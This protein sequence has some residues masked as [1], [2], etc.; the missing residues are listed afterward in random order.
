MEVKYPMNTY[1]PVRIATEWLVRR[2]AHTLAF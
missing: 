1:V 2:P